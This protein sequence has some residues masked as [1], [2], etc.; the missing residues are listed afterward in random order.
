MTS[1]GSDTAVA[2]AINE[3]TMFL[4]YRSI[5]VYV[6]NAAD[7]ETRP[8]RPKVHNVLVYV[9]P[10]LGYESFL[11]FGLDLRVHMGEIKEPTAV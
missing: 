11:P 1:S 7:T 5:R 4:L 3:T 9:V 10:D 6:R 8:A 2:A